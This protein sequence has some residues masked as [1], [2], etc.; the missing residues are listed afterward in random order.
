[1]LSYDFGLFIVSVGWHIFDKDGR[2][3][4]NLLTAIILDFC[5]VGGRATALDLLLKIMRIGRT[6]SEQTSSSF[7]S[8]RFVLWVKFVDSTE[9]SQDFTT[10]HG[11]DVTSV[12]FY[13]IICWSSY[14]HMT[15]FQPSL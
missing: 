1:M 5:C 8:F 14:K 12:Q 3:L 7:C 2:L 6:H 11:E 9:R 13:M 4:I 10:F 15:D